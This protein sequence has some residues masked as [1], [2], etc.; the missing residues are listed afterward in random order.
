MSAMSIL[1]IVERRAI[2]GLAPYT[3][4][5][6]LDALQKRFDALRG[7]ASSEEL[8]P[9]H[10]QLPGGMSR[11]FGHGSPRSGIVVASE[12]GLRA[13]GALDDL[14]IAEAYMAGDLD[15]TGDLM[16]LLKYRPLL[17]DRRIAR[18]L[19]S[20]YGR[21]AVLGQVRAD[22]K[23]IGSHYDVDAAFFELWLD[24]SIRGYSH[25]FFENDDE[26]VETAMERKFQYAID[27][28]QLEPG[29]RVLDI[30]GGWGS[31]VQYGGD[32]G[33]RVT[34]VTISDSSYRYM[35][36]LIA[37]KGYPCEVFRE[38]LFE[39]RTK[40]PFD[41]IVNLGVTEHLPDYRTSLAQYERLLKPGRRV[42]LDAYSGS[43]FSMGS[44]VTK[45]VFEGNTSPLNL[46]RYIAEVERTNFEVLLVKEDAY[47]YHL[48][49]RKWGESL[50]RV[51]EEVKSRWGAALYRR[52]RLYLYGCARAFIEGQLSAHRL[53]LQHRPGLRKKRS[54]LAWRVQ[55]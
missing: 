54:R 30:G 26:S 7:T 15:F 14:S 10:V 36:D 35:R 8:L 51:A 3:Q 24:R 55:A 5:G 40:E 11:I 12:A 19:W 44:V 39:F 38:H 22:K 18:Y 28:C 1:D 37:K 41:G 42:Y 27:A 13:L 43:R 46:A 17:M 21:A 31:F 49:C 6:V 53:L 33:L 9:F 50:D 25:A 34:S 48:T 47:N 20:T 16:E 32:R 45:W 2:Q 23:G 52:F 4:T 29:D